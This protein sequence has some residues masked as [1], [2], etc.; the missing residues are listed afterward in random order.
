VTTVA[1]NGKF[2]SFF[3]S[4]HAEGLFSDILS[5]IHYCGLTMTACYGVITLSG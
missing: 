3:K 2:I 5:V 4:T 1:V